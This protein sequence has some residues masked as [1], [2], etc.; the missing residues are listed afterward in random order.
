MS[1]AAYRGSG[2]RWRV[3]LRGTGEFNSIWV[4]LLSALQ[5]AHWIEQDRVLGNW[6][7]RWFNSRRGNYLAVIFFATQFD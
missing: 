6:R 2:P 1:L 7:S 3:H 5:F 4:S